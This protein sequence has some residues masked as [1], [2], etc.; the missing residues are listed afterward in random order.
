MFGKGNHK[1]PD[2]GLDAWLPKEL[3]RERYLAKLAEA[4]ARV[5]PEG[6]DFPD[7]DEPDTALASAPSLNSGSN[8][9]TVG[10]K[11]AGSVR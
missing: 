5:P 9:P 11:A 1:V 8:E 3:G 6:E 4:A 10:R 7:D 2:C